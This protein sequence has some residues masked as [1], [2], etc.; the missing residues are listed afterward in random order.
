[1]SLS[2][3]SR[4]GPYE[5][6]APLGAGGMGEVWKARDTR[7]ERDVA[8]KVL[9][10]EFFEDKER[11]G[12]FEREAKLLAAVNHP[13]IAAIHSFEE[14]SGRFLLVQELLEGKSLREV[15]REGPL[16]PRKVI[17]HGVEIAKGLAAAH[18]KGIVHRDLKPENLFLT[19]DGRI[20]ILDFGLARQVA[21]PSGVD[22]ELPTEARATD[23]GVVMGT[24]GYVS[25][26]QVRGQL[27]DTRSDIFAFGC[28]LYEMLTGERAFKGESA[29]ETMNAI[30]KEEPRELSSGTTRIPPEMERIVRHCLEKNPGERFQSIGDVA[31]ALEPA[32]SGSAPRLAAGPLARGRFSARR[33]VAVVAV[34]AGFGAGLLLGPHLKRAA[35]PTFRQI[36]FRRGTVSV[37]RFA[38]DGATVVYGA[39]WGGEPFRLYSVRLGSPESSRLELPDASLLAVSRSGELAVSLGSRW[40]GAWLP[41]GTL[42]RVPLSGGAPR[43]VLEQVRGADWA[44]GETNVAVVRSAGG[45]SR[46]EY[47]IGTLLHETNG[48][49]SDPRFS[50]RGDLIAFLD[51]PDAWNDDGAVALVGPKSAYRV[52]SPR[53]KTLR[54]LVWSPSGSEVWFSAMRENGA[55]SYLQAVSLSGAERTVLRAPG[56]LRLEDA[57]AEGKVLLRLEESTSEIAALPP[58]EARERDLTWLDWPILRDISRDG[59]SILFDETGTGAGERSRVYLRRT[60][61]SPAVRLW[62]IGIAN[63]VLAR[64]RVGPRHHRIRDRAAA[65]RSPADARGPA[66]IDQDGRDQPPVGSVL[67]G[68]AQGPIPR[69]G[70]G[71]GDEVLRAGRGGRSA[72]C[73]DPGGH[74]QRSRKR[75]VARRPTAHRGVA[76]SR[77]RGHE[78]RHG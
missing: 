73:P 48:W 43:E 9:P 18:A 28:V 27:A 16:P 63:G 54:G 52:L 56:T 21:I 78:P 14:I 29:V 70:A 62:S 75:A 57:T 17:Q 53:W 31:F 49:V 33:A 61:G 60:D 5:I 64:R 6:L 65:S 2:A 8:V 20:K 19:E 4:L 3:G 45:K 58:G 77:P 72:A 11:K 1:M 34:L 23:P 37:A 35:T 47:P 10:E 40:L 7:L 25:P 15:L 36:T 30:L 51:H 38:P 32:V 74:L 55:S 69:R 26:E 39:A 71:E 59:K 12:R 41:T 76:R 13:N 22:T 42:A 50:P 68:R 44:P 67:P 46:L 24:V 66:A